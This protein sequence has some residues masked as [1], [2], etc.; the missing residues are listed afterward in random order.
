MGFAWIR[1]GPAAAAPRGSAVPLAEPDRLRNE[2][3]EAKI[4]PATGSLQ[5]IQEYEKRGNFVSQQVAMRMPRSADRR[6]ARYSTMVADRVEVT[7]AT[8]VMGEITAHGRLVDQNGAVLAHFRQRYRLWRGS[9]VLHVSIQLDPLAALQGNPG[10]GNPWNCYYACRFAWADETAR[11]WRGVNQLRQ[12]AEAK[13][14]EAPNYVM[15]EGD[16][17]SVTILT[18]GLPFHR[19]TDPRMLDSLLIVP[20]ERQRE[21]ELGIGINV[22]DPLQESMAFLTPPATFHHV[23][24]PP[25][26]GAASWLLHLDRRNVLATSWAPLLGGEGVRGFQ[27]RLLETAGRATRARLEAFRPVSSARRV[28]FRGESLGA[29]AIDQGGVVVDLKAHQWIQLEAAW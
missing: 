13:R 4:N 7:A 2:F 5:S 16:N 3:F 6:A 14:F 9:R 11:L 18:G 21:F 27:V 8:Q 22:P 20:H 1:G 28:D 10:Q 24:G 12:R 29:C 17:R 15:V 25:A 26:V 19:R 23:T